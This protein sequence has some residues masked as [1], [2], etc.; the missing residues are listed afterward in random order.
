MRVTGFDHV[1][2]YVDNARQAARDLCAAFGFRVAGR[3]G[4]RTGL[5]A[6]RSVL[7]T[8]GDIRL[9]LTSGLV[10]DHPATG[11]VRRHGDGVANVALRTEDATAAYQEVVARGGTP[12]SPPTVHADGGCRVVVATV[13]G[14]G[15]V[16][17]H[18][19]ERH[20]AATGFLPPAFEP[21]PAAAGPAGLLETL[22]HVA[23]CVPAGQLAPT[24]RFYQEVFGFRETFEEYIEVGGQG[25]GSKVVQS[26]DRAV[27]FTVMEPDGDR[28][29]GQID[30]FLAGHAGAGVQHL[31]FRT[32]DILTAVRVLE[33]QGVGFLP[34]PA[35]YYEAL[36]QRLGPVGLPVADLRALGILADT[37]HWGR[38][39]QIFTRSLHAR[40]T[41]FLELIERQGALTFGSRN[42]RALYEAKERELAA[43]DDRV[44]AAAG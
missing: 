40:R 2:L 18:L 9:V 24:A 25:M 10:P 17:H 12:V 43:D 29:P 37:D 23:I 38:M 19:V 34:T 26:P 4:P 41:F 42:I 7:V 6:Q 32:A 28:R 16:R 27:T 35:S 33:E 15:D 8:Q 5:T 39:Y 20:D 21:E 31:A 14:F 44:D 36:E 11:F 30:E 22:D 1:E 3:P 13:A